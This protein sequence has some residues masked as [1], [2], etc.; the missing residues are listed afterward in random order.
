MPIHVCFVDSSGKGLGT[1]LELCG[2][3]GLRWS[4]VRLT[5]ILDSFHVEDLS[6]L[7]ILEVS[8]NGQHPVVLAVIVIASV[9]DARHLPVLAVV[10]GRQGHS[11]IFELVV[12]CLDV[13]VLQGDGVGVRVVA[14]GDVGDS[15]PIG[16]P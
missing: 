11:D 15:L 13:P 8:A 14:Q 7:I 9:C 1:G 3:M 2:S 12:A 6:V 5:I 10:G 4:S 16:V